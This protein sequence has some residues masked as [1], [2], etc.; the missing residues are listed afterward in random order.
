M[1]PLI[2]PLNVLDLFAGILFALKM[3]GA[4]HITWLMVFSPYLVAIASAFLVAVVMATLQVAFVK[5][6]KKQ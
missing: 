5:L 6:R 1:K 4:E 2:R 3:T